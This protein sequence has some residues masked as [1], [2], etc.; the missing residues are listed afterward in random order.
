MAN[1][2]ET[3]KRDELVTCIENV[4]KA[5]SLQISTDLDI[6]MEWQDW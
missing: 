2:I 5:A 3:S 4:V 6:T 1:F